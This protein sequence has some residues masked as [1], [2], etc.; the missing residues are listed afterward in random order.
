MGLSN[1]ETKDVLTVCLWEQAVLL[2]S[3]LSFY[4]GFKTRPQSFW[5][6]TPKKVEAHSLHLKCILELVTAT[7]W[8]EYGRSEGVWG[9]YKKHGI[10]SLFSDSVPSLW[11]KPAAL[12]WGP[13]C[14][15]RRSLLAENLRPPANGP[16][17]ESFWKGSLYPQAKLQRTASP[18]TSWPQPQGR[19][20]ART[21][22]LR[23]S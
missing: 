19:A 22:Q 23:Y 8:V 16:M 7:Q 15:K 20:W 14:S 17:S 3:Q 18:T 21:T 2:K 13:S 1:L 6:S 9:V 12:W 10:S 11:G 5:C 4:G